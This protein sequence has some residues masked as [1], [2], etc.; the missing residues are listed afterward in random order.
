MGTMLRADQLPLM[1]LQEVC[2]HHAD[3]AVAAYA[4]RDWPDSFVD[5]VFPRVVRS[6]TGRDDVP[7]E[8]IEADGERATLSS[9]SGPGLVGSR[10]ELLAWFTGRSPGT[11]L[12]PVGLDE[13]PTA[14]RW[15]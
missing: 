9:A 8:W 3:L 11:G 5:V 15:L 2:I 13:V 12:D 6:F 7:V 1:R 4:W 10:L 14:P